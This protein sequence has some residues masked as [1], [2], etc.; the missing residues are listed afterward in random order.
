MMTDEIEVPIG[1]PIYKTIYSDRKLAV[2][3]RVVNPF[4]AKVANSCCNG[5]YLLIHLPTGGSA[6]IPAEP[7]SEGGVFYE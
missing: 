5:D 6:W 4:T 2:M 1:T 7:L 3:F